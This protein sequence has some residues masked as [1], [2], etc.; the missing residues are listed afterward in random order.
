ML[1]EVWQPR[2]LRET[3][4]ARHWTFEYSKENMKIAYI[5]N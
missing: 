3:F 4:V 5:D 1:L 2:E